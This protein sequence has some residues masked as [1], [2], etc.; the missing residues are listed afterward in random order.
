MQTRTI[1]GAGAVLAAGALA[2]TQMGFQSQ[3]RQYKKTLAYMHDGRE[4][5]QTRMESMANTVSDK[6]EKVTGK[7]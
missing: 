2:M 6:V 7:K 3:D 1:V 4:K 5:Y